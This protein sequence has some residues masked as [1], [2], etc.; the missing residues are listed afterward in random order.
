MPTEKNL[1][2]TTPAAPANSRNNTWQVTGTPSGTDANSGN[3]YYD[4]SCYMP[5]M[6]GDTGSGGQDGL[7]PAPGAGDAAA[8]KFLKA[9]A[10]SRAVLF[11]Q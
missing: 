9:D 6:V 10:T 5:D 11:L 3:P 2:G 4:A 8:G 1:N 7:V